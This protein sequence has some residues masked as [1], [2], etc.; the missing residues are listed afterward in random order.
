MRW[1]ATIQSPPT[2][3]LASGSPDPAAWQTVM[4]RRCRVVEI[5]ATK[6]NDAVGQLQSVSMYEVT[7]RGTVTLLPSYRL[8]LTGNPFDGLTLKVVGTSHTLTE[9]KLSCVVR[10]NTV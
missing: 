9:T 3:K 1:T 7:L 4:M 5:D 8:V 6:V 2:T 10:S